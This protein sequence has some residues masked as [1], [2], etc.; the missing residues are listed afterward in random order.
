M[1]ER[2]EII[3]GKDNIEKLKGSLKEKVTNGID[4]A[5]LCRKMATIFKDFDIKLSLSDLD[6]KEMDKDALYAFYKELEF[7]SLLK[8]LE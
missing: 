4:M 1:F 8:D 3:L 2:T 7:K 5:F 6:K